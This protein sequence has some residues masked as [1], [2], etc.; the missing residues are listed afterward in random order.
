MFDVVTFGSGT[1]DVFLTVKN[2]NIADGN[3]SLPVGSKVEAEEI[4]FTSGGGGTNSAVTF[5]RQGFF[6]AYCGK[7]GDDSAG[8][9][10]IKELKDNKIDTRFVSFARDELTNHSV[11]LSAPGQDR[12]IIVYR[13]ASSVYD[14]DDFLPS[15]I[16][17]KWFYIAP[18]SKSKENFFLELLDYAK[19]KRIKV[20]ANPSKK[21]LES[22]KTR[23][24]L[25][26]VDILLLN[27][28]EASVLTETSKEK[29]GE[30]VK[31]IKNI[32]SGVVLITGGQKDVIAIY[33]D[34]LYK[35]SPGGSNPVCTTGAGDAFGSGFLSEFIRSGSIK[36]GV[37]LGVANSASCVS[38]IG[39][40]NG[41][42]KKGEDYNKVVVNSY[43]M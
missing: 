31:K 22:K 11:V 6:V 16:T 42:M 4:C 34:T 3:I 33:K 18:F 41:L 17:A 27:R 15:S 32:T 14:S 21:Q 12:T 36:R 20:M 1:R 37:Q 28:E 13:G 5:S 26:K 43:Y 39:A 10:I 25:G 29:M 19:E 7:V 30:V 35:A 9:Q 40:K 24:K 38:K 2:E 23:E 8:E